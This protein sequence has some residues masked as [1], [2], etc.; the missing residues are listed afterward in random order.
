MLC[1]QNDMHEDRVL[2]ASGTAGADSLMK[3]SLE[4]GKYDFKSKL[5][6]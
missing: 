1:F 5:L 6:F 3:Y 2:C 4:F